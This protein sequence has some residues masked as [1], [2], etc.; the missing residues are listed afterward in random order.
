MWPFDEWR[1]DLSED[2]LA[3]AVAAAGVVAFVAWPPHPR[4]L[5]AGFKRAVD[6]GAVVHWRPWHETARDPLGSARSDPRVAGAARSPSAFAAGWRDAIVAGLPGPRL[7]A[8]TRDLA[9]AELLCRDSV[10]ARSVTIELSAYLPGQA[11]PRPPPRWPLRVGVLAEDAEL[12]ATL[13]SIGVGP[14]DKGGPIVGVE[15]LGPDRRRCDLLVVSGGPRAAAASVLAHPP[16][17]ADIVVVLGALDDDLRR[18]PSLASAL[19]DATDARAVVAARAGEAG[20]Q[21]ASSADWFARFVDVL[22]HDQ[23]IDVAA[24]S[25]SREPGCP[26]PFVFAELGYLEATRVSARVL[27]VGH[28]LRSAPLAGVLSP[29]TRGAFTGTPRVLTMGE[30]GE[31]LRSPAAGVWSRGDSISEVETAAREASAWAARS[32]PLRYVQARALRR[33]GDAFERVTAWRAAEAHRIDVRIGLPDA[34]FL[35]LAEAFRE[36]EAADEPH[37]LSVVLTPPAELGEP[38]RAEILLPPVG[39]SS[40]ASFHVRTPEG[41]VLELRIS[42]LHRNRVLQTGILRGPL[43]GSAEIAFTVDAAPRRRLQVLSSRSHFDAALVVNHTGDGQAGVTGAAGENV[44]RIRLDESSIREL[45]STLNAMVSQIADKPA[46]YRTLTDPGS[47][48]L[49]RALARKGATFFRVLTRHNKVGQQIADAARIQ[50]VTASYDGFLPIEFAYRYPMPAQDASL[51]EHAAAGLEAGRCPAPCA[52]GGTTARVCPLG[53]W[54]TSKVIERH[55]HSVDDITS[56]TPYELRACE[57]LDDRTPLRVPRAAVLAASERAG[58]GDPEALPN[59]RTGLSTTFAVAP[60]EADGWAAWTRHVKEV[61][62][63][64][65]LVLLPHHTSG[66]LASEILEIGAADALASDDVVEDH[67]GPAGGHPIV[68]L[69]GCETSL[70]R[71]AFDSFAAH[72]KDSGAAIVIATIATVLGRDAAPVAAALARELATARPGEAFGDRMLRARRQLLR[73]GRLMVLSLTAYGD[74]DWKVEA[75]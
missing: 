55:A 60:A 67:V 63:P 33:D 8:R 3:Q 26:P 23:T 53:F 6:E 30:L 43:D 69:L 12:G 10:G 20:A 48:E 68:L 35:S 37:R 71:V 52:E 36:P 42:V 34:Q 22:A 25:A 11:T 9:I 41:G 2:E 32:A 4:F 56:A 29:V 40:T 74:A 70:A 66:R 51:C 15:V 1:G 18:I 45:T 75:G 62:S 61:P 49:L 7:F 47:E 38:Q 39:P 31:W 21:V 16:V 57:R 17:R 24:F 44:G 58:K 50:V 65:I 28:K 59:L 73:E 46:A 13:G 5:A 27:E 54:S 19:V 64:K 72:F 14:I